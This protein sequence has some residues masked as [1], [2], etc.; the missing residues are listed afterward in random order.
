MRYSF[1]AADAPTR[2]ETQYYEM[3]GNRALWHKGWK[4][5]TEHG[6]ISGLG[7]YDGDRWQLFHT[8]EDRAEAHDLAEQHPEKVEELKALWSAEAERNHVLPLNDMQVTGKD[9]QAFIALEF[10]I[11][12]PPSGQYTY[13]PGT[14]AVPERSA[15]NVHA[16]SYKVLADVEFTPESQGVIFAQGSRFGGH[17]LFVHEGQLVYAYNFLGIP[18]EVRVTG[19]APTSGRH[20]VGV[21]FTKERMGEHRCGVHAR[22]HRPS[23]PRRRGVSPAPWPPRGGAPRRR[24]RRPPRRT[25]PSRSCP[26]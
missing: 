19:A 21:E 4:A 12:V 18:P 16:V 13:Y 5:V 6:P 15:A 24:T 8:D 14:S 3:F 9:L 22:H 1:D 20:V 26:R 23:P 11:P 25:R 17:S 7:N 2:K 10:K